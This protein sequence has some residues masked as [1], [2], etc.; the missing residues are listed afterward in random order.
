[1]PVSRQ[2]SRCAVA[3]GAVI[4][5]SWCSTSMGMVSCWICVFRPGPESLL[6]K[7]CR[8]VT[9]CEASLVRAAGRS[10]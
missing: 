9:S 2:E 1:V 7:V 8:S 4:R 3:P 10:R 5:S 6:F